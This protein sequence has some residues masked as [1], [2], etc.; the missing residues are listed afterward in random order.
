MRDQD[1]VV[2]RSI[3]HLLRRFL[4]SRPSDSHSKCNEHGAVIVRR[5]MSLMSPEVIQLL[6]ARGTPFDPQHFPVGH[7]GID[8]I[9]KKHLDGQR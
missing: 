3:D 4:P 9:I 6:L 5:C 8:T 2:G 1:V 7:K